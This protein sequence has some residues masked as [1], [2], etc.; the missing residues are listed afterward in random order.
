MLAGGLLVALAIPALGMQ[1]KEPGTEGMSRS[2]PIIQT[3]DRVDAAF[4]GGTL[5]A[6]VVVKAKDVT[7]PEV[8]QAIQDLHD[9][10]I[11]TGQLSEPS[12]VDINPDK[13]VAV[14]VALDQGQG[15]RR[16]VGALARGPARRGRPG[17]GRQ[18]RRRRGRDHAA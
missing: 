9:Q 17:H 18:A 10:A 7:T 5:P 2:Q 14:V 16:R 6:N 3:L 11:A 15:H 1:F 8:K 13:T 4:P 12:N